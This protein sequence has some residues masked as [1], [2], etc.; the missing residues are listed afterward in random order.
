[1]GS[2]ALWPRT[3]PPRAVPSAHGRT[4]GVRGPVLSRGRCL[5]WPWPFC[6]C[7]TFPT[8]PG[9]CPPVCPPASVPTGAGRWKGVLGSFPA[10]WGSGGGHTH[11]LRP[12]IPDSQ[13]SFQGPTGLSDSEVHQGSC[14]V[15]GSASCVCL[16]GGGLGWEEAHPKYRRVGGACWGRACLGSAPPPF[17]TQSSFTP[18]G[19]VFRP[20]GEPA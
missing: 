2:R 17:S 4:C 18:A 10:A 8:S 16:Q 6:P 7:P 9:L 19:A 15:Q 1:M 20:G 11:S 14:G 13:R 5:G 12:D 3:G